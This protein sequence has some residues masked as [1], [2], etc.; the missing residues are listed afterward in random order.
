MPFAGHHNFAVTPGQSGHS[1]F[2]LHLPASD[3]RFALPKRS[4]AKVCIQMTG[5]RRVIFDL[6]SD[7]AGRGMS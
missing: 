1:C 5:N 2:V 3:D 7:Y 4:S 6:G